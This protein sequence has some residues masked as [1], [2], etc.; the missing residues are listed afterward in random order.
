MDT[1][2]GEQGLLMMALKNH[3]YH[4]HIN[5]NESPTLYEQAISCP[6]CFG[7]RQRSFCD[8]TF[9]VIHRDPFDK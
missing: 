6:Q 9:G 5:R 8:T 4:P 7:R 3:F 1:S 2:Y